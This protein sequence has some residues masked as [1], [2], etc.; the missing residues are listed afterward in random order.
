MKTALLRAAAAALDGLDVGFC[1]FD[2][3]DRTLA[4][5]QTFLA[6]F[7][8]HQGAVHEGE[9]YAENLRR[10]Y[11]VRLSAEE[12]PLI[13]RYVAEGVQRHRSQRRP[14]EF[15]HRG[16][17]VRVSSVEMGAFGR[18]RVW[19]KVSALADPALEARPLKPTLADGASAIL[20]SMP[21]G[22]LVVD[23]GDRMLWANQAFLALY[24][25]RSLEDV[26]GAGFEA[27]L[28][29][30]WSDEPQAP[31][32]LQSLEILSENQRFSGAP[33][34]LALPGERWVR[35]IEQRGHASDGRGCFVHVDITS[36]KRQQQAL[37]EAEARARASEA[38]YRMLAEHSSDT[39]ATL[40]EGRL[41]YV[42]PNV[43]KLLGWRPD[44]IL[45]R[46]VID[47]CH[48]QDIA[49]VLAALQRLRGQPEADYRARVLHADGRYVWIESR[50]SRL[51]PREG[52]ADAPLEMVINVR[53]IAARKAIEDELDHTRRRLEALAVTDGLTGLA[54]RRSFDAALE[55]ECRR[56]Q[57]EGSPL[58]LLFI[59]LDDFKLLNDNCGHLAGDDVLRQVA[60]VLKACAQ[61]AGDLAARYGGE[62]FALLLPNTEPPQAEAIAERLRAGIEGLV[63]PASHGRGLSVSIGLCGSDNPRLD[64]TPEA[65]LR[66]AD[67]ALYAAKHGGKNQV[68][69]AGQT[70]GAATWTH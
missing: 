48:P 17:R 18:L 3:H 27:L 45:G 9:P 25:L 2:H 46:P 32:F 24:G 23:A 5:N 14:Y 44:E 19:R 22:V 69:L 21:D 61:R 11:G 68:R 7:P 28:R 26:A 58:A 54:N 6:F 31:A 4:W 41:T 13:E 20:E 60:T 65:L 53:G 37:R 57:R 30:A 59:D 64:G 49:S 16:Y 50:A 51:P 34:E 10:F 39:V 15:D 67:E 33:F 55:T 38:G 56:A 52:D 8:E 12:L 47:F 66:L 36:M 35:V 63:A 29:Q 42:S 43:A 70:G 40:R 1:A 62:E